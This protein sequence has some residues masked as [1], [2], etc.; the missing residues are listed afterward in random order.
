MLFLLDNIILMQYYSCAF[1]YNYLILAEFYALAIPRLA[2][3]LAEL[4]PAQPQLV[5]I[6]QPLSSGKMFEL[7]SGPLAEVWC[8]GP[9]LVMLWGVCAGS[10]SHSHVSCTVWSVC[11]NLLWN[12]VHWTQCSVS[13]SLCHMSCL[14]TLALE[15]EDKL[16][17]TTRCFVEPSLYPQN[18]VLTMEG[19]CWPILSGERG[20]GVVH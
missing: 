20:Y 6:H 4:G 19:N 7:L 16:C 2:P 17:S 10:Y 15:V 11:H 3:A 13:D 5:L 18:S 8:S 12:T 9:S 1:I 14:W